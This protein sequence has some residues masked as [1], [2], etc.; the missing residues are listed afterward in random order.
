MKRAVV[1]GA[2]GLIGSHMVDRLKREGYY[3]V[4]IS[5]STPRYEFGCLADRYV[6]CDLRVPH[7]D[8]FVEGI[9]Q[10]YQFACE[11][12]GLGYIMDRAN[13]AA[14]LRNSTLIDLNVLEAC[15]QA[16][17]G[18]VFFASSGCVYPSLSR[19]LKE[20]DAYPAAPLNEFAWQKLFAERLYQSYATNYGMDIRIGR[21]F[22]TYGPGM[23]WQE[24]RCKS[25]AALCRKIAELKDGGDIPVWGDGTQKRSYTYIDDTIEGIWQLMQ[26]DSIMRIGAWGGGPVNI[27]YEGSISVAD[28]IETIGYVAKKKFWPRYQSDKPVGVQEIVAD[29]T[30]FFNETGTRLKTTV[31]AGIEKTYPWVEQQVIAAR[32]A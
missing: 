30:A 7:D 8:L 25:V 2:S 5:R 32:K 20:S 29:C 13:D 31:H 14:C 23:E 3:V 11:V 10:V 22:N 19:P 9:D 18:K 21:L 17:V 16:K 27:G 28:L 26:V 1:C 15:R 6:Q 12:G 24:P 4:A